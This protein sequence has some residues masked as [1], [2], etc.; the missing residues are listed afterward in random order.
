LALA[1]HA[2]VSVFRVRFERVVTDPSIDR[3][4]V[5]NAL[6]NHARRADVNWLDGITTA[7]LAHGGLTS[8][9]QHQIEQIRA[10]YVPK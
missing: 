5:V 7:M 9:Q 1:A 2:D 6:R 4:F 8:G 10:T 3:G